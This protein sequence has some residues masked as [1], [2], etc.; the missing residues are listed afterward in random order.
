MHYIVMHYMVMPYIVMACT[1]M[2]HIGIGST[3]RRC[4]GRHASSRHVLIHAHAWTHT[5]L[6]VPLVG[7]TIVWWSMRRAHGIVM[8]LRMTCRNYI[9]HNYV[10]MVLRMTWRNYIGHNYIRMVLRMTCH[11]PPWLVMITY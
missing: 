8:L 11:H 1:V 7:L 10:R 5:W 6:L 4:A 2:S 9:G 3:G